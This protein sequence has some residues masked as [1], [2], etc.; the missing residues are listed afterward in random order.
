MSLRSRVTRLIPQGEFRRGALMIAGGTGIA[1]LVAILAS[2][3]VTRLYA[4]A[5]YGAYAVAA[6][7][8]IVLGSIAC[9]RYDYAIPL[10]G[11][12]GEA[13][14]VLGLCVLV[15]AAIALA[16]LLVLLAA[17]P[18]IGAALG[19]SSVGGVVV[20]VPIGVLLSGLLAALTAWMIR[21]RAYQEIATSRL[22]QSATTRPCRSGLG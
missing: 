6:S 4:P 22:A 20:L 12:D 2:P 5:D 13:A 10:P 8:V 19:G 16:S 15:S 14:N 11:S 7:I 9:L 17:A 3:I 1:Q 18:W 21:S